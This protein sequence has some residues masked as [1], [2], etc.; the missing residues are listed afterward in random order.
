MPYRIENVLIP[1][2]RSCRDLGVI[3]SRNCKFEEHCRNI[4]RNGHF[5]CLQFRLSFASKNHDFLVSLYVTYIRPTL[6]YAS[7]IWSPYYIKDV[8]RVEAVQRKFTKYLPGMFR[9]SYQQRLRELNLK[10]LEERRISLDIILLYKIIKKLIDIP[11]DSYFTFST[12]RTRGHEYKLYVNSTRINC[13]KY[14]FCNRV[15]K[16]WNALPREVVALENLVQFKRTVSEMDFTQYCI[17]RA[18]QT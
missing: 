4:S 18:H 2:V 7:P 15:V 13:F 11:F 17:G 14:H 12:N 1:D 6:E 10:T 5:K 16:Y 3:I 9:K 8:D